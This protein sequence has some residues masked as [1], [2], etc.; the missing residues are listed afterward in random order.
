MSFTVLMGFMLQISSF[1]RL[2]YWINKGKFKKLLPRK[3]KMPSIDVVRYCLD[4]I[5][6]D[7][8]NNMH[9]SIIKTA[10]E[11]KVF[12]NGTI[13]GHKVAA[14]GGVELFESTKKCC[15]ECLTSVVSGVMH[16]F[17]RSVV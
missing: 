16:Y 6:I 15:E 7:S 4:R 12:R 1:N 3:T 2:E 17:H 13:D 10:V 8:L 9:R 11:N 14:I 5:E